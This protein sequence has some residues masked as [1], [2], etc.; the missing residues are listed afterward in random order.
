MTAIIIF[1]ILSLL[2]ILGKI[3]RTTIP[4]L[5]KL[6]LP[7]SVIGGILGL[8]LFSIW[9]YYIANE[10]NNDDIVNEVIEASSITEKVS[11][12]AKEIEPEVK[13][14]NTSNE[15]ESIANKSKNKIGASNKNPITYDE[16]I[17]GTKK[18]P[19]FMINVIFA[20]LFLGT[21]TP[22]LKTVFKTAF[23]QIC[24]GQLL[25]WG[26][27]VI[28]LG[29]AG[30]IFLPMFNLNPAFGNLLEIGFQGGHGTV[31]GV[32]EVFQ[33]FNWED[34][35]ALGFTVATFGMI[36]GIIAGMAMVNWALK[37][38]HV[39]EIRTYNDRSFMERIGVYKSDQRPSAGLQTVFPDSI[40]SLAFHISL[41][42]ISI[43]IGFGIL[44]GLQFGE[45]YFFPEAKIRFFSGFPLFPL[46]MI[47]GVILQILLNKVNIGNLINKEQMQRLSGASLD[48]LVVAAIA[49]IQLSVVADNFIPLII[50]VATGAI[51]C[52]LMVIFVS[53]K[54][55]KKN[56]FEKAIAEFGQATGVTA[57]GLML[58]RTV[59]PENKTD[60]VATFG[61]KQLIH[62]PIMGGGLWT[63]F[64]LTLVFTIGWVK[65]FIV[66]CVMLVIWAIITG[67]II[68][69][70]RSKKQI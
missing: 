64:A 65:V 54:L 9:G 63:A 27:Y 35:V 17:A 18:I 6:Y 13:T 58:L 8:I 66:S 39:K 16:I 32:T 52:I 10:S 21:V 26:Q 11:E 33:N 4:L 25:A 22:K 50:M 59:D 28:G 19:G 53:P 69:F 67:I 3:L 60:A 49:T 24:M 48:F 37:K 23:P 42:G 34:G 43:L 40:D 41:I 61:Y 38:G 1:C 2:L 62:E 29:L 45:I 5:Q 14:S 70:N 44:K 46:C 57:T 47:G 55:F 36:I 56:W 15:S 31:G 12:P 30:F 68:F 20:T 7:S 51:F